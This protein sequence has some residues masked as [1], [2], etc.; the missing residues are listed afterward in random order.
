MRSILVIWICLGLA[1]FALMGQ[2]GTEGSF[3]G[4]V[5]DSTGSSVPNAEVTVSH[6]ATGLV[7]KATT[8][9]QGSFNIFA[10]PIGKYSV[11]V[12]AAGFKAWRLTEAALTVGDRSRISP[13]L[14]VGA[15]SES[16]SVSADAELLQTE[17][18]SAETVVQMQ[19]IRELPLDT[20]NPLA[21]VALVPGMRW[22]SSQSGGERATYVQGQGLRSNKTS[23]QLDGM[24]SNAPMDEGG[25]A[26][27]NVDAVAE[28]TVESLNFS[29]ENGRSPIQVKIA[30]KSG[31]NEFHGAL[32][33]FNQ[34]NVYNAR[35]TFAVTRPRVRRNQFGAAIGG[36]IIKNKTFFFANFEGTTIRNEQV[37]NNFA[38]TPAMKQGDFSALSTPIIDPQT[39]NQFAGNIIP[40]ARF[41]GASSYFLPII[42]EANSPNG[43]FRANAGNKNDV[44]EGTGRV[45]H[46]L[47]D[48]Q[49]IYGRYTTVRQPSTAFG[50]SPSAITDDVV[51]QHSVAGNYTAALS[52]NSVLTIEGGVLSTREEYTNASLGQTNDA[53]NAGLQGFPTEGREKWIG[54]PNI[55]LGSGYQ[56]IWYSG[57][58]VP[59]AL[60]GKV[61]NLKG[62]LHQFWQGHT[63][64]AGVEFA[65]V[66][67]YGDH[68]SG[69]ARGTY[70]FG[71]LYTGNGFADF[72]L[73][74]P[75]YSARNAPLADF[76]TDS[77]PYIGAFFNDSWR[78][79]PNLSLD[80]GLRYEHWLPRK[81][82][83]N[84]ASTWDPEIGKVVAAN[85]SNGNINMDAFLATSRVAAATS[86]LWVTARSAGYNDGLWHGNGNWAPRI[87][88]VYRPFDKRPFVIR[89][90]YGLFY[91]TITGNRSASAAAN[92]PFWGVEALSY[93]LTQLQ[94]W[95]TAWSTDPN[96]FG[97]F[98]IGESQDPRIKAARTQEWNL[99]LQTELPF[100][101][102]FTLTYAGT[103]VDREVMLVPYNTPVVGAHS[104]LQAD[105]PIPTIGSI[106]R[107]ENYGKNWYHGLQTKLERRFGS[108]VAYTFSY[109]FSR[110]MGE[111]SFGSD[112]YSSILQYSPSWYNRGRTNFD[113]RHVQFATLLW[114]LPVG[115]GKRFLTEANGVLNAV[116]GGWNFTLTEQA[117]SGAP[118]SMGG[119]FANLGNG[120]GTRANLVGDPSISNQGPSMWFNTSAFARPDL[121]SWGT[122]PLGI[123]EGPGFLQFNTALLKNFQIGES[124]A[125][126]FR[127]EAFNALNRANYNNPNTNVAS[128]NFGRITS[129]SSPRYMQIGVKFLF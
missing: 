61:Y 37:W 79:R 55:N 44:W 14:E 124:K 13:V 63:L 96:T 52:A 26:I 42:Q 105:R 127:W 47:T 21:L 17:K 43:T 118:L 22:V 122:S 58:G 95:E 62:S 84:A 28:F 112:E 35:N 126:Q 80:L 66:Q 102:A 19:Q 82:A 1:A 50:Y 99:T 104:N 113:Y 57:W 30:T 91:N 3:F 103:S 38:V 117:R 101:T 27:P 5:T 81:N 106:Q 111:N 120:D 87:G 11:T 68:G 114:E 60:Y 72:L 90:A 75:S 23:F 125:L 32:W 46:Q 115:H 108:G 97:I 24:S 74:Y 15:T 45:D 12:E 40:K 48:G 36:P 116:L 20:R 110:S 33:E 128:G 73:G 65:N 10:L 76:G 51:S 2:T 86:D 92:L 78:L 67:T 56:G 18:S 39:G 6:Q 83:R 70:S 88:L 9:M 29:A 34:N 59:G 49:R 77:A 100:Q 54:P 31:S 53:L 121:Y 4:V 41:S 94:P 98:S 16:I 119:G 123:V 129:A 71:N 25:T 7:R 109:A 93:G 8:D 64:A 85:E 107:L 89:G 69:N